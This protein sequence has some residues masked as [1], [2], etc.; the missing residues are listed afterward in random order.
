M[1]NL[2]V[3]N[4]THLSDVIDELIMKQR[5]INHRIDKS[6]RDIEEL[7]DIMRRMKKE[8]EKK[9]PN[10]K[11]IFELLQEVGNIKYILILIIII[12]YL[13]NPPE[14]FNISTLLHL[15]YAS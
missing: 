4:K 2:F 10:K 7:R 3:D 14:N 15:L 11:N 13:I 6:E 8:E 9:D 1:S 5:E 12:V